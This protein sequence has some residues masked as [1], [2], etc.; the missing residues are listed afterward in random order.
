MVDFL[1]GILANPTNIFTNTSSK[2]NA[3][4]QSSKVKPYRLPNISAF[5][6]DRR[7]WDQQEFMYYIFQHRYYL[8]LSFI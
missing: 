5:I 7:Y 6:Y 8:L 1:L 4:K 2:G 3:L